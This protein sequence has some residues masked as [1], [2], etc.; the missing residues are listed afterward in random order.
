HPEPGHRLLHAHRPHLPAGSIARTEHPATAGAE[1]TSPDHATTAPRGLAAHLLR[2]V[3]LKG[4]VLRQERLD[5]PSVQQGNRP[6]L[7]RGDGPVRIDIHR[8]ENRRDE[9]LDGDGVATG[10]GG[11]GIA[12]AVDNAGS[13]ATA[14]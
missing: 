11:A 7:A 4:W 2:S 14:G 8:G 3:E 6:V 10:E 9:I 12:R 1:G 5:E 13:S